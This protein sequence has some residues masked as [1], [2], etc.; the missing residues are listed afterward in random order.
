MFTLSRSSS[1]KKI[2][3]CKGGAKKGRE[4]DWQEYRIRR[5]ATTESKFTPT[6]GKW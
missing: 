3:T 4:A 2:P 6:D 5:G 1:S